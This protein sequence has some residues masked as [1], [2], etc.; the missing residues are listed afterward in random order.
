MKHTVPAVFMAIIGAAPAV[1]ASA[2]DTPARCRFAG[3]SRTSSAAPAHLAVS[4]CENGP[5]CG[6]S[7]CRS[8]IAPGGNTNLTD[9][10]ASIIGGTHAVAQQMDACRYRRFT[11]TADNGCH[12]GST[13]DVVALCRSVDGH[14]ANIAMP[15]GTALLLR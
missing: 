4:D 14:A 6:G 12:P 15:Q 9:P 5:G 3:N 1:A 8:E 13:A 7:S 10:R 2:R 11:V